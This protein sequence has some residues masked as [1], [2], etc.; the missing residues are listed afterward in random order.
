MHDRILHQI[1][2]KIRASEY[3][4]P[5]HAYEELQDDDLSILDGEHIRQQDLT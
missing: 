1:R 4:V 2:D 5:D 3:I